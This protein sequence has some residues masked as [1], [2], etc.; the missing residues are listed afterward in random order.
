MALE[1]PGQEIFCSTVSTE[2]QGMRCLCI[3]PF[4][5]DVRVHLV[6]GSF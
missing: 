2:G 6:G 3:H 5:K 1:G 4:I